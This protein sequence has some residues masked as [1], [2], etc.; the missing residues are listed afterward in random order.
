MRCHLALTA[1]LLLP[2]QA[3]A[4]PGETLWTQSCARC[5]R[6]VRTILPHL[7][8]GPEA[9]QTAALDHFLAGH[10]ARDAE[11]RAALVAWLLAQTKE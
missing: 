3:G 8:A 2:V 10:H 7:P 1:L 9:E 6:D 11:D 5:H 4:E